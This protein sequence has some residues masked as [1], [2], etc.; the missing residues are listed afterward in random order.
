[1][2]KEHIIKLKKPHINQQKVLDC[3]TRFIVLMCGRRWGKSVIS[4]TVGVRDALAGKKVAYVTPTYKLARK[5]FKAYSKAIPEQI[6][7]FNKSELTIE[8]ITDGF[9]QFFSGESLDVFRGL[10]FD[11]IIIDEASYIPGLKSN[12]SASL[13]PTLTDRKGKAIFLSTPRG[14][15]DF[16]LFS[17]MERTDP[18]NWKTFKFTSYD[19]PHIPAEEIDAAGLE[20]PEATFK[21]EYLAD[22]QENADNPFGYDHI[23]K[24][25]RPVSIKKPKV[26]GIDL[27]KSLDFTVITGLDE[28]GAVCYTDRWQ[29]KSWGET[30]KKILALP[31]LPMLIDSTGVGDPI[32]ESIQAERDNVEGLKFTQAS[33]QDLILGLVAAVQKGEIFYPDNY[34]T[35]EMEIFEYNYT[36]NGVKYSAPPGMHDDAVVSLAL[37]RKC[38]TLHAAGKY[39][40]L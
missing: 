35:A 23:K 19:N 13:R 29:K 32:V 5:F 21:Q 37:A 36:I 10:D 22:P 39:H 18:A 14:K 6:A 33:K 27:A 17:L 20:L 4:Q 8:L 30:T 34:Y 16:Y 31:K 2:G 11:L 38:F 25:I 26:F 3:A 24:N 7:T 15:N 40:L 1:M 28:D 9:I 12:W